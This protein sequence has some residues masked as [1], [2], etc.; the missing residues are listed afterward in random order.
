M[1]TIRTKVYSF[2]ELSE[3]AQQTAINNFRESQQ[4]DSDYLHFFSDD[5]SEQLK[6]HHIEIDTN[7]LCYSLNYRQGDGLSFSGS[8]DVGEM[9][10]AAL[11]QL[12]EKRQSIIKD[13]IHTIKSKAN[14]GHYC[15]AS[16][17]DVDIEYNYNNFY[18][19][20]HS[21]LYSL[22][23]TVLNHCEYLYMELCKDF[24][25]Q[26]YDSI[27]FQY[28]D[29]CIKSNIEANDYQFL[30]NGNLFNL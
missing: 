24:E 9:V 27:E 2:N 15:Y 7:G 18:Q 28:S 8:F 13:L 20:T 3:Q 1:K 21:N 4:Q 23:E 16:K 30:S 29:E 10:N 6:R 17:S 19:D 5:I 14:N 11:P 25:K 22:C 26:G 12:S